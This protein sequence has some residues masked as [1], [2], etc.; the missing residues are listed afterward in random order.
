MEYSPTNR[1]LIVISGKQTDCHATAKKLT[2][3]LETLTLDDPKQAQQF[4]GQEFDAVIFNSFN[5]FDANAFGAVSGTIRLGGFLL[6]LKPKDYPADSLFLK[7]FETL[8]CSYDHVSFLDP[9]ADHIDFSVP[10]NKELPTPFATS[11]QAKTVEAIIHVVKGHRR[12]PLVITADRGRGKSASL[13]LAAKKLIDDGYKNIIICAP[14]KKAV[15]VVYQYAEADETNL[16]FCSPDDLNRELPKADLVLIDEAAA[17]PVAL[18]VRFLTHYSRIVFSSTQHGYE[19]SGRGFSINFQKSLSLIAPEWESCKLETP[20]RWNENDSLESFVFD[21][22]LLNAEPAEDRLVADA[23]LK[24]CEYKLIDKQSLLQNEELLKSLFGLLVGAHYQTKPSDLKQLL[25]D[26]TTSIHTLQYNQHIIAVAL[27]INEGGIDEETAKD[28]FVGTRR[29]KGHLVAQ[30]LAAN[31]GIQNAP[32][33]TG[34]RISRI[35]VHPKLQQQGYGSFLLKQLIKKSTADYL[36]TSFGAT[37]LVTDFWK[38]AGFRTAYLGMKRDASSGTHSVLM[39]YPKTE[40]GKVL[41]QEACNR[42]A[43]H[44]PYLLA[45]PFDGLEADIALALLPKTVN[46]DVLSKLEIKELEAFAFQQRGY[47]NS[48][49]P[50]WKLVCNN[51]A[52]ADLE[53]DEKESLLKKVLQRKPWK[54]LVVEM[55]LSGKKEALSLFRQTVG[56]LL[57]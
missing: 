6:L 17:I 51:L 28:I 13:G 54:A 37:S 30:S 7:R 21:A 10:K 26:K 1:H 48:I 50:L 12:R 43:Q 24:Q 40:E 44:F 39:L 8:L 22:L 49:Y 52:N 55:N 9:L 42:F 31:V 14:S 34:E 23:Q 32:T 5:G 25:D 33:L 46:S 4:L 3:N 56:K 27:I 15:R 20:I 57:P 2:K 29:L 16:R 35:A 45:E 36:S 18:L 41:G 47:E 19:G 53:D 38:K 11:D